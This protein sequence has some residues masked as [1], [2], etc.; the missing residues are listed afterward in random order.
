MKKKK[1]EKELVGVKE[2]ARR[3]NVSIATVDRVLHNRV[4]V[5]P[6]TKAKIDA[7]IEELNYK[8]NIL[9]RRLASKEIL[10]F[11][12]LIPSV[13]EETDYWDAPLEGI[14]Q[15]ESEIAT[16]GIEIDKYFFDQNDKKSFLNES[17]KILDK[18]YHGILLAP[19]FI[20][21][22]IDFVKECLKVK[23]PCVFINS[24]LPD[25]S[26][27]CYIG[28]NL[29]HAGAL[30]AHLCGYLIGRK[31]KIL[32]VNISKEIDNHHHLLR[33]EQGFKE[34]FDN[35]QKMND[36][37]KL[38]IR[39]TSYKAVSK[40]LKKTFAANKID[41]V[42]VTNSRVSSVAKFFEE[43][44]VENTKLIGFDFLKENIEYLK[45][46]TIDFLICQ[47]P[48]EQGYRGIMALYQHFVYNADVEKI[49]YM[50]IDIITKENYQ[51][52]RN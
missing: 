46:E 13:S 41:L 3:A 48:I 38:D 5:S 23:I 34:Y 47:K 10:R 52:Y 12:V 25:I 40:E 45:K 31:E 43:Q 27:L 37:L 16:Y 35:H 24:D 18:R 14:K 50:P 28:P 2:I 21:E 6:K 42:F 44:K 20:E 8:P 17:K 36:I 4:G 1:Q 9:A 19:M 29:Y 32:I 33:K 15:A 30:A 39:D 7:I 22:S 11:A 51:F 49:Y 26:S